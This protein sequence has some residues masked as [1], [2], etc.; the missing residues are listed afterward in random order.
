MFALVYVCTAAHGLPFISHLSFLVLMS[1]FSQHAHKPKGFDNAVEEYKGFWMSLM[2]DSFSCSTL[3]SNHVSPE[4]LYFLNYY[5]FY[6]IKL[7]I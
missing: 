2:V 5:T 3:C 7:Y 1:S 6:L 4:F